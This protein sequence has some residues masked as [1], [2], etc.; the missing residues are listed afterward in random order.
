MQCRPGLGG[1]ATDCRSGMPGWTNRRIGMVRA[2]GCIDRIRGAFAHAAARQESAHAG[3][4]PAS[5]ANWGVLASI[6]F[7]LS[8][9]LRDNT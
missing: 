9:N 6:L 7:R 2:E 1:G 8:L 4:L 3:V 5:K